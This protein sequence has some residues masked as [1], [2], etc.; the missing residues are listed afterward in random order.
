MNGIMIVVLF[1]SL[2]SNLAKGIFVKDLAVVC[3]GER[4]APSSWTGQ[5]RICDVFDSE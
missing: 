5:E 1:V 2:V 3:S 4:L